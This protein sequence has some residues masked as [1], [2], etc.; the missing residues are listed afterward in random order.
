M[1]RKRIKKDKGRC[2]VFQTVDDLQ[3]QTD[4]GF[5]MPKS[6]I[7]VASPEADDSRQILEGFEEDFVSDE[8]IKPWLYGNWWK[9]SRRLGK[10]GW[11]DAGDDDLQLIGIGIRLGAGP[12]IRQGEGNDGNSVKLRGTAVRLRTLAGLYKSA[13]LML[14]AN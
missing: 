11:Q 3:Y 13:S 10:D 6:G 5:I 1:I 14:S 12:D 7:K 2:V 8:T 4:F 9:R